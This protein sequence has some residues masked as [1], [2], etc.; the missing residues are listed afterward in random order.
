MILSCVIAIDRSTYLLFAN[1]RD[2]RLINVDNPRANASIFF[3]H[4]EEAAAV[5]FYYEEETIFWTDI[6]LEMIKGIC[7]FLL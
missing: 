6:G 4:V 1:R 5:D 7:A 2:I 3:S